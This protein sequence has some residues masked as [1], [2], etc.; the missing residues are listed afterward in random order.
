MKS[1]RMAPLGTHQRIL[2][3]L[4]IPLFGVFMP[5]LFCCL[6]FSPI[7][8]GN[9][10]DS[11]FSSALGL[12][13]FIV[14]LGVILMM[15][16]WFAVLFVYRPLGIKLT[17]KEIVIKRPLSPYKIPYKAIKLIEHPITINY[18]TRRIW[19]QWKNSGGIFGLFGV[20]YQKDGSQHHMFV[21]NDE[22]AVKISLLDG[23][24]YFISPANP[25]QFAK[26]LNQLIG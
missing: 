8:I 5:L 14:M 1:Y 16:I 2:T 12:P 23:R 4:F 17:D 24:E 9:A 15:P 3:Y 18:K 6:S 21:T 26:R 13:Y 11:S 20:I 10:V 19:G 7:V 25:E 22:M